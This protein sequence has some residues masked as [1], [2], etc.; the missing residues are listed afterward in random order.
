MPSLREKRASLVKEMAGLTDRVKSADMDAIKRVDELAS[1]IDEID[2]KIQSADAAKSKINAFGNTGTSHTKGANKMTVK[3]L[4]NAMADALKEK[5][6]ARG[7]SFTTITVILPF[8]LFVQRAIYLIA[9][10][11][12]RSVS[13]ASVICSRLRL[14]PRLP[15]AISW[16]ALRMARLQRLPR[17]DRSLSSISEQPLRQLRFQ[18][19]LES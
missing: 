1:E 8:H 2:G 17:M 14:F 12:R 15:L 6:A 9:S 10:Y 18:K 11:S 4:G 19:S 7:V 5:G 3:S 16:L 13:F